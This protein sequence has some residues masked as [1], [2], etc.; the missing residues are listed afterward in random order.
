MGRVL[1]VL[2]SLMAS[3]LERER[4][5]RSDETKTAVL[6]AV[7]HDLRSPLTAISTA[8]EMLAEPGELLSAGDRAELLASITTSTPARPPGR[9]PARPLAARGRGGKPDARTLAGGRARR[10]SARGDRA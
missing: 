5:S 6:R 8:T 4:L 10:A 7:S 9:Q 2:V 1:R 3:A